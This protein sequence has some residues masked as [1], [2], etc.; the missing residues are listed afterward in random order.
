MNRTRGLNSSICTWTLAGITLFAGAC[1]DNTPPAAGSA[2][3]ASAAPSAPPTA[4]PAATPAQ[5][6]A[7][8]TPATSTPAPAAR[9]TS[10]PQPAARATPPPPRPSARPASDVDPSTGAPLP[11]VDQA[12][13]E[14]KSQ[15]AGLPKPPAMSDYPPD[16]GR[17][18]LAAVDAA[19]KD[20]SADAI[21]RVG[22]AYHAVATTREDSELAM[23]C[24]K[25]A[26]ALD[27]KNPAWPY[28]M[29]RMYLARSSYEPA[30]MEFL[31]ALELQPEN[32]RIYFWLGN[33][34]LERK[35]V[36]EARTNYQKYA[37]LDPKS[38]DALAGI[39][40]T[41][42]ML[43]HTAEAK[44]AA[45]KALALEPNHGAAMN[46]LAACLRN[47]GKENESAAAELNNRAA[48]L[49]GTPG[50]F[51]HD[52]LELELWRPLGATQMCVNRLTG[53]LGSGDVASA[54]LLAQTIVNDH[55]DNAWLVSTVADAFLMASVT[56][57]GFAY[58]E[59]AR[60]NHPQYAPAASV[61]ASAYLR[62]DQLPEA[63]AQIDAAI[64]LNPKFAPAHLTRGR[65][66]YAQKDYDAALAAFHQAAELQPTN[67]F[68]SMGSAEIYLAQGKLDEAK[69]ELRGG[70]EKGE[71]YATFPP[72]LLQPVLTLARLEL[73]AGELA[74]AVRH[75]DRALQ[76]NP[77]M[78]NVFNEMADALFA[79]KRGPEAITYARALYEKNPSMHGYGLQVGNLIA[80]DGNPAK[81]LKYLDDLAQKLPNE[82]AVL[83]SMAQIFLDQGDNNK[84]R[85]LLDRA[86]KLRDTF[87]RPYAM[88][89]VVAIKNKDHAAAVTVLRRGLEK[90]PDSIIL[91][92][93]LAWSLAT[94][95]DA[96]VR[97]PEE[98]IALAEKACAATNR[99]IA[100]LLDTLAC[101][102]AAAG[103]FEDAQRTAEEAMKLAQ[104]QHG[105]G[106]PGEFGAR[107]EMFKENK[108]FIDKG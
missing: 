5:P 74:E 72:R 83:I 75:L 49:A 14:E 32:A 58:A 94:S 69:A 52:R 65:I 8:K 56:D 35:A 13:L 85:I 24:Y 3:A 51:A 106:D 63:L 42:N 93:S 44:A 11:P 22:C 33:L 2:P 43:E 73:D 95:P 6:A 19:A 4:A 67:P 90:A 30:R 53:L 81:G 108:A 59:Q 107:L 68:A 41:E 39:G 28:Y 10:T 91:M 99:S 62:K 45:E 57:E 105:Q 25:K 17:A 1:K 101:S 84:A 20:P 48:N 89:G 66:L 21:G 47:A 82:P 31:K 86:I 102:Y 29:G 80:R 78:E 76:I 88:L 96:S 97:K 55:P 38:A 103:R 87:D 79:L 46:V 34:E 40:M 77:A 104:T 37:E 61:M 23:D 36:E 12:E 54:K 16:F 70:I 7:T 92:N 9:A 71:A 60:K 27:P 100:N 50:V 15:K 18:L 98:A 64:A 26:K